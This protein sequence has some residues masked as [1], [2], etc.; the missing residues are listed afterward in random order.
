[1]GSC[2]QI[3]LIRLAMAIIVKMGGFPKEAGNNEAS[4]T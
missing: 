3:V 2:L 1:M 4:A